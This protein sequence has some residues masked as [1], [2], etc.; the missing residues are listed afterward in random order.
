MRESMHASLGRDTPATFARALCRHN[1]SEAPATAILIGGLARGF[2]L[3]ER[4]LSLQRNVIESLGNPD[5][6]LLLYLKVFKDRGPPSAKWR[7]ANTDKSEAT[8]KM[9]AEGELDQVIGALAPSMVTIDREEGLESVLRL[10]HN[11]TCVHRGGQG[12]AD[13]QLGPER[14]ELRYPGVQLGYWHTLQGLW[15]M[16]RERVKPT[17]KGFNPLPDMFRIGT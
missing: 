13:S 3:P 16:L 2:T 12:T 15:T 17:H 9:D 5:S 1:R 10:R 11:H 8:F 14:R 6:E 4:W 7:P